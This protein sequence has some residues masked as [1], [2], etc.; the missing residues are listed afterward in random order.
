M[1]RFFSLKVFV[2]AEDIMIGTVKGIILKSLSR[3]TMYSLIGGNV[4]NVIE[5]P[6]VFEQSTF[7]DYDKVLFKAGVKVPVKILIYLAMDQLHKYNDYI[8]LYFLQQKIRIVLS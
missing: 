1:S 5:E 7:L 2:F 3:Q 4:G 8:N 6:F